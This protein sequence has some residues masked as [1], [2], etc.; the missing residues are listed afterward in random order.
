MN[1]FLDKER[2]ASEKT[3]YNLL[4][5]RFV[6]LSDDS[7]IVVNMAGQ[8][9]QISDRDLKDFVDYRL[10][11]CSQSYKELRSH[12]FLSDASTSVGKSLLGVKLKTRLNRLK[13]FTSLHMFVV[14]LRCEHSCPYC[15][16]SRQSDDRQA[17]D[18]T[19]E[20]ASRSLEL[21]FRSPSKAI[22]IEFQ[23]GEPL[24]NF[25]LIQHVVLEAK[26]K[27]S[28]KDVTFVIATNLALVDHD[29]LSFCREHDISISTSLDGPRDLHNGNRP[30]PGD[31]SHQKAERGIQLARDI[32]GVH[33]VSALMTTTNDSIDRVE[34][35]V[36]EYLR[37][38]FDGIF[39]RPLSPYG[40]A[41]KTKRYGAYTS[42]TWF[43]FYVRG[44]EYIIQLNRQGIDFR[45]FYTATVLAKMLTFRDPGYMD[46]RSPAGIGIGAV[47][48]NYD[49]RVF[50]SDEGRMLAEMGDDI[51]AIGHV[52]NDTY[53]N[54]FLNDKLLEPL[55]QSFAASV[56]MCCDCA[57][58]AYCGADPTFHYAT[59]GDFV[60]KKPISD[61][62]NRQMK[63]IKY[64]VS[65]YQDD[66]FVRS[67]FLKWAN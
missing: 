64:L 35:I 30:R 65:R 58:E 32:L 53:E 67:L 38:N 5:F 44:L 52:L 47:V 1:R 23:G 57:F 34:E 59:Q 25:D 2:F 12:H 9:L 21:A 8:F 41:I 10:D 46:L 42:D 37:L 26:S 54:I 48:Y 39:L 4:P 50:A 40:F 43:D 66:Q 11:P 51:F 13:A 33:R 14:S 61:F 15:Q 19:P 16:V 60:G 6:R 56:P 28:D 18:M 7:H 49:G 45:E 3:S 22:K 17:Y 36:D 62:C 63:M 55:E 20:I 31:D 24:L 27:R 29:M